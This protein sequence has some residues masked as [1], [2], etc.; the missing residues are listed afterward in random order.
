VTIRSDVDAAKGS[1]KAKLATEMT[2]MPA[3]RTFMAAYVSYVKAAFPPPPSH[4]KR[5]ETLRGR[6]ACQTAVGAHESDRA[7]VE[8]TIRKADASC[9]A[10]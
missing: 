1:T 2:L 6:R 9:T 7:A 8:C 5:P 3:L 4:S 10:S